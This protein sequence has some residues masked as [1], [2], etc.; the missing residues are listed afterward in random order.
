M[1]IFF[2]CHGSSKQ[3]NTSASEHLVSHV[4]TCEHLVEIVQYP[5]RDTTFPHRRG[6]NHDGMGQSAGTSMLL[7]GLSVKDA[8]HLAF[9]DSNRSVTLQILKMTTT[10]RTTKWTQ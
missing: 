1:N 4:T 2:K 7:Q 5:P 8:V 9:A 6:G 10:T 3:V